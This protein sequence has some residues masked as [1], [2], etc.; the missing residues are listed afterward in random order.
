MINAPFCH[1]AVD[2]YILYSF[3][4]LGVKSN[5][6]QEILIYNKKIDEILQ[7]FRASRPRCAASFDPT[8]CVPISATLSVTLH[9]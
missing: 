6:A 3:E 4:M 1:S 2:I 5:I 8:G 9:S 7:I